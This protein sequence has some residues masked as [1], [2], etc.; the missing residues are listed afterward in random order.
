MMMGAVKGARW[1]SVSV[2][3]VFPGVVFGMVRGA[4]VE[5]TP[6]QVILL[7]ALCFGVFWVTYL[8]SALVFFCEQKEKRSSRFPAPAPQKET[9][10]QGGQVAATGCDRHHRRALE[11]T[12]S[13]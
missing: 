12:R 11:N 10:A 5:L 4:R 6:Q 2:S 3:L 9:L 8:V 7:A 13:R 1:F